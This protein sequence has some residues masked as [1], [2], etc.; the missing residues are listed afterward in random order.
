MGCTFGIIA[1]IVG[2]GGA[3]FA[4]EYGSPVMGLGVLALVI[5]LFLIPV[6]LGGHRMF[7]TG[8]NSDLSLYVVVV[9]V[10]AAVA[11]PQYNKYK[12]CA[13]TSEYVEWLN[14]AQA[15]Y[16]AEHHT[17]APSLDRLPATPWADGEA[18]RSDVEVSLEAFGDTTFLA[19]VSHPLC[20]GGEIT[21]VT[22]TLPVPAA[23]TDSVPT[24]SATTSATDSVQ[25]VTEA[26]N[27]PRH[28]RP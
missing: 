24:D 17:F 26:A 28:D 22:A 8:A 20:R 21:E 5:I 13:A 18:F 10:C 23:T 14:Q 11:I 12:A 25:G 19:A 6:H 27:T 7:K 2:L 3:F 4:A 16:H 1:S 15:A 9:G